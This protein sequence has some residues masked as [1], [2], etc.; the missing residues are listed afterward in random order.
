MIKFYF[1]A[2]SLMTNGFPLFGQKLE[3]LFGGA[4]LL[5]CFRITMVQ[6]IA[7]VLKAENDEDH[8]HDGTSIIC[9]CHK[10][11]Y[12]CRYTRDARQKLLELSGTLFKSKY[13]HALLKNNINRYAFLF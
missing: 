6:T 8:G 11:S 5:T 12:M 9:D 2:F 3:N 13:I 7:S 10:V 1:V 4:L